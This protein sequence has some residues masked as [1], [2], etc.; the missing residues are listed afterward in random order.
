MHF[1]STYTQGLFAEFLARQYLRLHGFKIL[2]KRY[3][4]GKNTNRAEID[5]IAQKKDLIVFVEVK[6]R[7]NLQSGFDA[8]S[9]M[10]MSR[11]RRAAESYLTK[12]CWCGNARFDAIIVCGIRINW[13]K[14]CI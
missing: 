3:I 6:H 1:K 14:N 2:S 12:K 5:I 11:L 13:I 7:P 9:P 10:Q 8:I 4:T